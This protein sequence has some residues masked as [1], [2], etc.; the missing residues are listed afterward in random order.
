MF[1]NNAGGGDHLI[2]VALAAYDASY[3]QLDV[4]VYPTLGITECGI[5]IKMFSGTRGNCEQGSYIGDE[6][7]PTCMRCASGVCTDGIS[8]R[9]MTKNAMFAQRYG[10]SVNYPIQGSAAQFSQPNIQQMPRNVK[11]NVKKPVYGMTFLDEAQVVDYKTALDT[12]QKYS[13]FLKKLS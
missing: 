11:A 5:Y 2:H 1:V 10:R 12:I 4:T 7:F 13:D 6:H 3:E 9:Q 8:F